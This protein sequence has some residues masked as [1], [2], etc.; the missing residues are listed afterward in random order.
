MCVNIE[1]CGKTC[2]RIEIIF[3]KSITMR[4]EYTPISKSTLFLP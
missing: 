2:R 3:M 1:D 4:S